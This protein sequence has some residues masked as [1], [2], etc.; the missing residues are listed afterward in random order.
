[1]TA[2]PIIVNVDDNQPARYAR[3][4]VLKTAG[5]EVHEASTGKESLEKVASL[6][7]DVILLDVH[8]PDANG[9][10]ICKKLKADPT[11]RLSWSFKFPHQLSRL[12]MQPR[13]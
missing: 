6:H 7:P 11:T 4:R 12:P 9:I 10:E 5:F 2:V 13:P 1:M 3:S 8:L